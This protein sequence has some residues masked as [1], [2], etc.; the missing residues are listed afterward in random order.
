M[1]VCIYIYKKQKKKKK[2]RDGSLVRGMERETHYFIPFHNAGTF[3]ICT[4]IIMCMYIQDP[5]LI[6]YIYIHIKIKPKKLI[7]IITGY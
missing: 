5:L 7:V 3:P 2:N 4:F 1:C 6:E